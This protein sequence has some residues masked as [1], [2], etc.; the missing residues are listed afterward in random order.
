MSPLNKQQLERIRDE[1]REQIKQTAMKLFARKGF[2]GTKTSMI[3][4]EAGISEGLIYRHYS[5]KDELFTEIV[6]ELMDEARREL[7][8]L[9]HLPGTPYEQIKA[10]TENMLDVNHKYAFMLMERTRKNEAVP[11]AVKAIFQNHRD[12]AFTDPMVPV[13]E[14][15]Q[16]DGQFTEGDPR[17]LL[18]WYFSVVNSLI[19]QEQEHQPYGMPDVDVLM[20][21]L[22]SPKP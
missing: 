13:V 4:A 22:G 16:R 15:G 1:R 11:E 19:V 2:A 9:P 5:S 7:E 3:A 18:S 8:H 14:Q 6:Q 21:M 17:K 20:R 12:L 10:L